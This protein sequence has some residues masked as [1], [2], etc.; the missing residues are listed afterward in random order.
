[1]VRNASVGGANRVLSVCEDS[2]RD[3]GSIGGIPPEQRGKKKKQQG[4]RRQDSWHVSART[5]LS[6]VAVM[7][8][9]SNV[10]T[11][12]IVAQR[13]LSVLCRA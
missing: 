11:Q 9:G 12:G 8:W 6:K 13:R 7:D 4:Q 2:T 1:M 3:A 5:K 10:S